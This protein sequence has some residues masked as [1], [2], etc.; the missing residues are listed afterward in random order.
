MTTVGLL[1]TFPLQVLCLEDWKGVDTSTHCL[2]CLITLPRLG[3]VGL[4]RKR[5]D[6][7]DARWWGWQPCVLQ[8]SNMRPGWHA[9]SEN[10]GNIPVV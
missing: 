4:S 5:A 10:R 2:L 9:L 6:A 8:R 3:C 7:L 1:S